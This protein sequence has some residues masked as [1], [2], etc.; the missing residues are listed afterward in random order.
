[1]R[2]NATSLATFIVA[3]QWLSYFQNSVVFPLMSYFFSH[4]VEIQLNKTSKLGTLKR[5][6]PGVDV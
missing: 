5:T 1:M 6:E 3:S 2:S 4:E